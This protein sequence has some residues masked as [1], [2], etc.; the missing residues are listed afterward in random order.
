MERGAPDILLVE[1]SATS[2][3]LFVYALQSNR[4]RATVQIAVDGEAALLALHGSLDAPSPSTWPP[5]PRLVLLDLHL[6]KISGLDVLKRLR[7]HT[8]TRSLPVVMLSASAFDADRAEALSL[9]ANDFLKKPAEFPDLC[10][11]L[12][13]LERD[14]L[15]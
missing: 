3:E 10:S 9:G 4:S 7:A 8:Y 15:A 2:A 12:D 14:W 5:L 1:D 11:M 13:Q 6:P